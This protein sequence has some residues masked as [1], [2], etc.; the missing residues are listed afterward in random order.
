MLG[1]RREEGETEGKYSHPERLEAKR[2]TVG[3]GQL[4]DGTQT[5]R[6]RQFSFRCVFKSRP[7]KCILTF[8]R[9]TH[10]GKP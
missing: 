5:V 2:I 8:L 7:R 9:Q 4:K 10:L 1:F 3:C 6:S